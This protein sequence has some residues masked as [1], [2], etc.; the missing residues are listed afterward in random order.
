[1]TLRYQFDLTVSGNT[2]AQTTAAIWQIGSGFGTAN[3]AEANS[4][5]YARLGVNFTATPGQFELRYTPAPGNG[6]SVN[7][8]DFSGTQTISWYLNHSGS[9]VSYSAPDGS[10]DSLA[11][12]TEDVW[13]GTSRAFNDLAVLTSSQTMSDLKFA[14]SQ[15]NG[16]I[17]IDNLSASTLSAAPEP[18]DYTLVTGL[19]LLAFAAWRRRPSGQVRAADAKT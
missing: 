14:F 17:G 18:A 7:S 10:T 11:D 2:A 4:L 12:N 19:G 8:A 13:V 9:T 5:V 3:A 16:A 6:G 15:G 1:T